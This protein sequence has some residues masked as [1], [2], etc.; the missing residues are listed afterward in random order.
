M[1]LDLA[2]AKTINPYVRDWAIA[3]FV[4]NINYAGY[5]VRSKVMHYVPV[6][7]SHRGSFCLMPTLV[8]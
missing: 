8:I 6:S 3:I 4:M 5:G 1:C 2:L 7:T